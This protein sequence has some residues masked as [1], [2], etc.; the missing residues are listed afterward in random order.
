MFIFLFDQ[1]F[2]V[3]R[4][5]GDR[6]GERLWCFGDGFSMLQDM[7]NWVGERGGQKRREKSLYIYS[8]S[9]VNRIT[10]FWFNESQSE[11]GVRYMVVVEVKNNSGFTIW[12][13]IYD[14]VKSLFWEL[15]WTCIWWTGQKNQQSIQSSSQQL[16]SSKIMQQQMK[17]VVP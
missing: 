17:W 11:R 2:S 8:W 10:T 12:W 1:S 5:F 4:C 3:L 9:W 6:F 15:A 16:K 14:D 13:T 7:N